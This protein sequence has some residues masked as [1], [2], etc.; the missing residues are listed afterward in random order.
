MSFILDEHI[1]NRNQFPEKELAKYYGKQVAWSLDGKSIVASADDGADVCAAILKA[2][3]PSDQVVLS[4]VP[5]PEETF[6]GSALLGV[7]E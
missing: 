6:L 3:I 1:R 2:G 4:Y 5:F 7:E